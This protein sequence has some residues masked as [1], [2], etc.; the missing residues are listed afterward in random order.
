[1]ESVKKMMRKILVTGSSG[2]IGMHLCKNLLDDGYRVHGVDNMNEYYDVRLKKERLKVLS[3]YDNFTFDKIDLANIHDIENNFK[4]FK[5]EKVVNLAA[6]A[7]VR[8]SL[9]N[10][11]AYIQSNVVGFTN[12]IETCKNYG[13][14][15]LIY[16]SSSSVYGG[17]T[18]MPFSVDDT[19]DKPLSIYA[20][21]KK[22]NELI[23]YTYSHL[24]GL[25]TT[26]LRFFTVYG[27][28]GRP[29][30][31][32]FLFTKAII[33]NQPIN[34]FNNGN[35]IRD[36]TFI[37]DVIES[38]FR[39]I[40]KKPTMNKSFDSLNPNPSESWAPYQIFNVGNSNPINLIEYIKILEKELG[41]EAKKNFM[42]MQDGDVQNTEADTTML[43]EFI[44]F[45]PN[46][47][48]EYGIREFISWYKDFYEIL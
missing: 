26:G 33:N 13:I 22:S 42:P 41:R 47:P 31:A 46:T 43:S 5:P 7:G 18:S 48:I 24:Y 2:F 38:I 37:D 1:M 11:H 14:S 4:K 45:K 12:L 15:G 9:V 30:M 44:N 34:I 35:M 28:W 17:N 27:P 10:P 19:V 32:L 40:D 16:A 25:N 6:Q 20:A 36:F 23:A 21:S 8:Y 39:L 29:D 3:K